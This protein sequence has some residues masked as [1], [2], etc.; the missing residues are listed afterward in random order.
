MPKSTP[1]PEASPGFAAF[2]YNKEKG[3]VLGRTSASWAKIGLFYVI[4]YTGLACFF[5]ALLSIF[6]YSFTDNKAPVL[7]GAYSVL[8][9]KPGMGYQPMVKAEETLL[10]Y[11]LANTEAGIKTRKPYK[12]GLQN[13]LT[14]GAK[15]DRVAPAIKETNYLSPN[16]SLFRST[17]ECEKGGEISRDTKPCIFDASTISN[18]LDAGNCPEDGFGYDEG[19]PCVAI[20]MNRI[21][22]FVPEITDGDDI[23]IK[24]EGEHL[25]D[26]DN[27]GPISYFPRGADGATGVIKKYYFPFLGQPHYM[28]PLVFI[29]FEK[30]LKNVL[31]QV[32]CRPINLA[33]LKTDGKDGQGKVHFEVYI[34]E[35]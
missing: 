30:V 7:T 35:P 1:A 34:T 11:S 3:E 24:C 16:A 23:V 6:L 9:P 27:V 19:K 2:L 28:T 13:F 31:V 25:A 8:P 18:L 10:T 5:V 12:E 14:T 15:P 22:E 29:K 4:Y 26:K 33:N 17:A 32:V 21:F 20:K